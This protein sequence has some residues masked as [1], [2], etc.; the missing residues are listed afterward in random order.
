M[1]HSL[2]QPTHPLPHSEDIPRPPREHKRRTSTFVRAPLPIARPR[3]QKLRNFCFQLPQQLTHETSRISA[4]LCARTTSHGGR[5]GGP[6]KCVSP[7]TT[8]ISSSSSKP[9]KATCKLSR[10]TAT[11]VTTRSSGGPANPTSPRHW[12]K[13]SPAH[14]SKPRRNL[15]PYPRM[16]QLNPSL[17]RTA[18]LNGSSSVNVKNRSR[19]VSSFSS[20]KPKSKASGT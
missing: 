9:P 5:C 8:A 16:H 19:S 2:H 15:R 4:C 7:I 6:H 17:Q 3:G 18:Q 14:Q 10:T 1:G 20:G 12:R 13:H 11:C